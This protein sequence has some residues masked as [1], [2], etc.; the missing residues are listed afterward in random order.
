MTATGYNHI[1]ALEM[2]SN[3]T[4]TKTNKM[5]RTKKSETPSAP[6]S[7]PAP[8]PATT[9]VAAK[10]ETTKK[11]VSKAEVVVP[12]VQAPTV[13]PTATVISSEAQLASL[14]EKLKALSTE[15]TAKVREAVKATQEA[16]KQAKKEQRDSK[17]KHKKSPEQMTPEEK[18]AW[19]A[20]R[21]NNAF[22]KQKEISEE[23]C[24]FMGIPVGSKRSQTEVT[25]FIAEYVKTHKIFDPN[26]KRRI[27][28]NTALAKLLRVDDKTELSYLNL[29]KYLKV[30]FSKRV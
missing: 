12:T 8:A 13:V 11:S 4:S 16:A 25:K 15:F 17:K 3:K 24:H 14:T 26:F 29:Q 1:N 20:R 2:D 18:A 28:P 10:K 19:E 6:V 23:L 7:A 9:K 21:N 22:L 30:H 27:I 5:A